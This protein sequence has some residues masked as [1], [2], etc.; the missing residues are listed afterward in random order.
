MTHFHGWSMATLIHPRFGVVWQ[1]RVC[2]YPD[3]VS[4]IP[5]KTR[6]LQHRE[7]SRDDALS[8]R[9]VE[10]DSGGAVVQADAPKTS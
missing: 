9:S 1:M 8:I 7:E 3:T 2:V 6:L 10:L 5:L 4:S